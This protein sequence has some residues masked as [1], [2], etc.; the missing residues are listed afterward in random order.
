MFA[1]GDTHISNNIPYGVMSGS[2]SFILNHPIK[3]KT[4]KYIDQ[5]DNITQ[6]N[7]SKFCILVVDWSIENTTPAVTLYNISLDVI[8]QITKDPPHY[9]F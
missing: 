8:E 7:T 6:L 3:C 2:F 1:Y 4:F 5:S 9:Q